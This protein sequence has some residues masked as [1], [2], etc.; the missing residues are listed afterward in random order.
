LGGKAGWA[1]VQLDDERTSLN[2]V[3]ISAKKIINRID[4][5]AQPSLVLALNQVFALNNTSID[6]TKKSTRLRQV[7]FTGYFGIADRVGTSSPGSDQSPQSPDILDQFHPAQ[8]LIKIAI[9]S[10]N[11]F[12]HFSSLPY[13]PL[14][15]SSACLQLVK[16]H[17]NRYSWY[18]PI[19]YAADGI[20][21]FWRFRHRNDHPQQKNCASLI[22]KAMKTQMGWLLL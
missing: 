15:P 9:P 8:P 5:L 21:V 22:N 16:S 18:V 4:F 12:V 2:P 1:T 20:T 14:T 19:A 6:A 17:E 10:K 13:P 3:F 11:A 7:H